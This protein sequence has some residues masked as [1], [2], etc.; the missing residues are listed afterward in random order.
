MSL[1]TLEA[2]KARVADL[3]FEGRA[4]LGAGYQ[5]TQSGET[6]TKRSPIDGRVLA[7]VARCGAAEV[8]TAVATARQAFEDRRWSGLAPRERKQILL[9]F[10]DLIERNSEELA[11]LETLDM[12]KP[13][14]DAESVDLR[15]LVLCMRW[16][17]EALDKIYDELAPVGDGSIGMIVREPIGVVGAIIPWNF[18]LMLAGWKMGPALG[19]GNSLILKPAEQSPLSSLRLAALALE[20]GIPE[21]VLQ[22]VPGFGEEAGRALA[23]HGDVDA[24]SFTGSGEVGKLILQYA[25]QSNMK[26]VSLECGGKSPN[27]VFADVK[28]L[29]EAAEQAAW[30]VFFNQGEVCSAGSRLLAHESVR[31]ELV[32]RVEGVARTM[33]VGNPLDPETRVGA[34]VS[35]EQSTR[36]LD[37]IKIGA[38][39]GASLRMGGVPVEVERGGCYIP[40][41]IF[42][43]VRGEMRIAQEE[44]F[45]PVL[46]VLSFQDEA[47]AIRLANN[48]S[49][50][51]GAAVWT[52]DINTAF[53]V[54]KAMRSGSVWINA[55]DKGDISTPFGGYKQ[56]GIGRD[57]SLHA[58]D[59]YSQVK[60][61]WVELSQ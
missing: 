2:T 47:E 31:E 1:A 8:D 56:S 12:G 17:A 27:I 35:D 38:Q 22:V 18:P 57:K 40:P 6:F 28:D 29:D 13:I 33:R 32:E 11:L 49:Y 53:R 7:E 39:E 34:M 24:I 61:L 30:G 19:M 5:P 43:N 59:K 58:L 3:S 14:H 4:F 45:G 23:L 60:T 50:G 42:D 48:T 9:R 44:I 52:R 41:T 55:Y 20:A 16:Y 15:L 46:S 36:V 54:G 51:L 26:H 37:Y 25:G 10:A 21:G